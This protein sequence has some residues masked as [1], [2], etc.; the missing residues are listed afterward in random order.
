LAESANG[1]R[2]EPVE[3]SGTAEQ[4]EGEPGVY[5]AA[6]DLGVAFGDYRWSIAVRD[7][8]TGLTSYLL[9]PASR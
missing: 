2:T 5:A 1:N 4:V 8:E 9:V 3:W 7:T 6:A